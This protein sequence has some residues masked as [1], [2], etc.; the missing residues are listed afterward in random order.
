MAGA[1]STLPNPHLLVVGGGSAGHVVP[2]M[3]LLDHFRRCGWQL[4]FVGSVRGPE[5]D[6]IEPLDVAF[7]A[8][9]VGKL[10]RYFSLENLLDVFRTL[11]GIWQAFWLLRRLR[12]SIV[13]SKGGFVSVPVVIAAWL[14]RVPVVA[15]ESDLTPGLANRLALPFVT[16]LCTNFPGTRVSHWRVRRRPLQVVQT[17]TPL[18]PA[19][20]AGDATR[21]RAL[22]G[23]PEG[24]P[25][26]I[27]VGGS[28]GAEAI[29]RTV[30]TALPALTQ[31]CFVV[32]VCGR[33][34]VD[35]ALNGTP[36]Y[37][38]YEYVTDGWGDML[39]AADLVVSRAGANALYE[40]LALGKPNLLIPL[41]RAASRGD[42]IENAEFARNAGYSDVLTEE[43]LNSESLVARLDQMFANLAAWR[44]RVLT[45]GFE[46]GTVAVARVIED[47]VRDH[48]RRATTVT[49]H[50]S[51]T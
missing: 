19:L 49:N 43:E 6:L 42:Q 2:S 47:A 1:T 35:P 29:N 31:R 41:T 11:A 26:L 12:P 34:H 30:R 33:G 17:G 9:S 15:H 38:A 40:L 23:A 18:R 50:H 48:R 39:A 24:Q 51:G 32:H 36:G 10:R 21:G 7:Y 22:C 25:L 4:S 3:P 14:R 16:A 45:S 37:R 20:T 44:D 27:I 28:L 5:R 13:F 8:V 46:D